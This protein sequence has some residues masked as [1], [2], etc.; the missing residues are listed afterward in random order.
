MKQFLKNVFEICRSLF[1]SIV[2]VISVVLLSRYS[3]VKTIKKLRRERV[4]DRCI[5]LGNG[6]SLSPVLKLHTKEICQYDTICVNM[7]CASESF[8][9]IKPKYYILTDPGFFSTDETNHRI[10]LMK[11]KL[12]SCI[13]SVN[14]DMIIFIPVNFYNKTWTSQFA[15][16]RYIRIYPYNSTAI[17]GKDSLRNFFLRNNLG[18]P[19]S[20]NVLCAALMLMLNLGYKELYLLGADHNWLSSFRVSNDNKIYIDVPHFN[21]I[22]RTI[23]NSKLSDWLVTQYVVFKGHEEIS[24]YANSINAHVFNATEGSLVDSYVRKTLF[25]HECD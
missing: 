25:S 24:I 2:S 14:W 11:R 7:F 12:V 15:N 22:D 16:N 4:G 23:I 19:R 18:M 20:N 21:G 9:I 1:Y 10:S 17:I 6:P 13:S 8:N 3:G 5:I